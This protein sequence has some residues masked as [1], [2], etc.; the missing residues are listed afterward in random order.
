MLFETGY[1]WIMQRVLLLIFF[2]TLAIPSFAQSADSKTPAAASVTDPVLSFDASPAGSAPAGWSGGPAGTIVVDDKVVHAGRR[3]VRIEPKADSPN[4]FPV[5]TKM[6][7]M[8]FSGSVIELRGFLRTED[9]SGFAGLWMREDEDGAAVEFDNMQTRQLKG[10]TDWTEYSITLPVHPGAQ[11][12]YFGALV[13]GT[14][15][16]W[17]ADVRLLVDGKP[18]SQVPKAENPLTILNRDHQFDGGS[19]IVLSSLTPTRI[20]NLALLGKVW[21]FLKYHHP[22]VTSG[23]L[24]WDYEL[25]RVMPEVIAAPDR[26]AAQ[27]VLLHW[28]GGLGPVKPCDPCAVLDLDG[29][30]L[31]PDLAW[32]ADETLLGK[33]LAK[34]LQLI[35]RNRPTGKQFYVSLNFGVGNPSFDHELTYSG[36]KLPDAGSQILALYRFWNIV[37]YWSP[38]RNIVGEDWDGVLRE[39]LPRIALAKT[40]EEYQLEMMKL[41]GQVHDTHANLWSSLYHRPPVG[42]C[43]LPVNLRFLGKSAAIASLA[44]TDAVTSNSFKMGDVVTDLDGQPVDK[45]VQAWSPYYADSNQAARLR[46]IARSMTNGACGPASIGVRRGTETL[47][48]KTTRIPTAGMTGIALTHDLPGDTFRLLSE[49]VAYLKLSSVKV[50]DVGHY[51]QLAANTKGLIVDIRNYPSEFVP[52]ALGSHLVEQPTP[53]VK[54]TVGDLSNPGAFHWGIPLQIAPAEPHYAG[55]VVIL[56]DEVTQSSAEY[57]A[58]A[59]RAS[60]HAMVIGSTTAGADGNVSA[61]PLPGGLST[62]I[63]GLG[64]FYPDGRPTQQIGIVPDKSVVPTIEG[65]RAGR[66][67]V[68]EEALWQILGPDAPAAT[69]EKLGKP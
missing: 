57:T 9:V 5:L 64:V 6:I 13:A 1:Y 45:L 14:G 58:M 50:A 28:I 65:I 4:S 15:R 47:T 34:A 2:A 62:M 20:D 66:D 12:L 26:A 16:A 7:P 43:R 22:Q 24:H 42:D 63:S 33:D 18:V 32:I 11:Q 37:E 40:S 56:V 53:F 67:E 35:Q 52:F 36:I 68:L 49:Q 19:G 23:N 44:S 46:D 31:G 39:F 3:S 61:I 41:I 30:Q 27:V 8:A 54:F 21:G 17:V 60:P 10:T 69:I 55:K 38:N 29:V 59:L 25:F 51:L 48:V